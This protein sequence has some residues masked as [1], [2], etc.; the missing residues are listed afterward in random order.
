MIPFCNC[1][2]SGSML[3]LFLLCA[4]MFNV[5]NLCRT[6][7]ECITKRQTAPTMAPNLIKSQQ[8]IFNNMIHSKSTNT[9]IAEAARC[10]PRAIRE[11]R[12]KIHYLGTPKAPR[13]G[14]GR[15]RSITPP[16][17]NALCEYLLERPGLYQSEMI[18]FL[19]DEFDVLVTASS[20]ARVLAF[21]G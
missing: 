10:K 18:V 13:N 4:V 15:K 14:P 6:P 9:E 11:I 2:L 20:I 7:A 17:L 8:D 5:A 12:S 21:K 16:M 3:T 1:V 19:W